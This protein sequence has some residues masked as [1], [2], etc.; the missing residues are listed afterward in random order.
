MLRGHDSTKLEILNT[1]FAGNL[2]PDMT[3]L[4]D[5][6]AKIGLARSI[7]RL[8]AND[9]DES[10]WE[11]MGLAVHEKINAGFRRL[12]D[13]NS[14]RFVTINT[15]NITLKEVTLMAYRYINKLITI[16]GR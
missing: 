14:D 11:H 2:I 4:C 5:V 13:E 12:A 3:I 1:I 9:I 16:K 8:N 7:D 6:D 15:N 10:R